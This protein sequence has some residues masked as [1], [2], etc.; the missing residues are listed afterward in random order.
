MCITYKEAILNP[1]MFWTCDSYLL[2][3]HLGVKSWVWVGCQL[4]GLIQVQ[5]SLPWVF[6]GFGNY[7]LLFRGFK[8]WI[9]IALNLYF[10]AKICTFF[11]KNSSQK[12]VAYLTTFKAGK[13]NKNMI[14]ILKNIFGKIF[15]FYFY[16][17]F[18]NVV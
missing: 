12:L 8:K 15:I 3:M 13:V 14:K 18:S 2:V 6:V 1:H 4:L 11:K 7:L 10:Q 17:I 9:R 16:G 5:V